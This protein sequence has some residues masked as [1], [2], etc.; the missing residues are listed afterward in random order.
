MTKI[1]GSDV[2]IDKCKI[3]ILIIELFCP[4]WVS[5]LK[6]VENRLGKTRNYKTVAPSCINPPFCSFE[7][8]LLPQYFF[9]ELMFSNPKF[10]M[11]LMKRIMERSCLAA[12]L[13]FSV[14]SKNSYF[15]FFYGL[16]Y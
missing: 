6:S 7:K 14:I 2:R 13:N 11:I 4:K 15:F 5:M 10:Q 3:D 9:Y 12:T 16:D 1:K 8:K